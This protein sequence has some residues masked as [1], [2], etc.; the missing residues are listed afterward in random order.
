MY[1]ILYSKVVMLVIAQ[2]CTAFLHL[3]M[4]TWN[5]LSGALHGKGDEREGIVSVHFVVSYSRG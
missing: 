5:M 2:H 1:A 3:L 4:G